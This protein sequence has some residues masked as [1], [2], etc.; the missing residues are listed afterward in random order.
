MPADE[1]SSATNPLDIARD[2][3]EKLRTYEVQDCTGIES[4]ASQNV[5]HLDDE[6]L[7]IEEKL[8]QLNTKRKQWADVERCAVSLRS[9]FRRLPPEVLQDIMLLH[10][11]SY[12]T[13]TTACRST[14][15]V[16][17]VCARWRAVTLTHASLWSTISVKLR[18]K[19][20]TRREVKKIATYLRCSGDK[21]LTI[22]I[23]ATYKAESPF[24][25]AVMEQLMRHTARWKSLHLKDIA[26]M[27]KEGMRWMRALS[28]APLPILEE[29]FLE[30]VDSWDLGRLSCPPNLRTL[31]LSNHFC[32][33][34]PDNFSH[35]QRLCI[36][37]DPSHKDSYLAELVPN[38]AQF[39]LIPE[40]FL[41]GITYDCSVAPDIETEDL[42]EWPVLALTLDFS[43]YRAKSDKERWL[44]PVLWTPCLESLEIVD[45]RDAILVEQ[46]RRF[47]T[48]SH[49]KL[50]TLKI[51]SIGTIKT[52]QLRAVLTLTPNLLNLVLK[53]STEGTLLSANI[54]RDLAIL[55][56]SYNHELIPRLQHLELGLGRRFKHVDALV[57]MV[58]ARCPP[59]IYSKRMISGSLHTVELS[60]CK[61]P[62]RVPRKKLGSV[63][64]SEWD[65][66]SYC[67]SDYDSVYELEPELEDTD[68]SASGHVSSDSVRD[69]V[70][71]LAYERL[72]RLKGRGLAVSFIS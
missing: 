72:L 58:E 65:L 50:T 35:I 53:D 12:T 13:P 63:T 7:R 46:L 44:F 57:Y 28:Q 22:A 52:K 51:F 45:I 19:K 71:Q 14:L 67:E 42:I 36:S 39:T 2:L 40:V 15:R 30:Y 9:A 69:V 6:I 27:L 24:Y 31:N 23:R 20:A 47:L 54:L 60:I 61:P 43:E 66:D 59:Q 49:A 10:F 32:H 18:D 3:R 38:I 33:G 25:D 11:N 56:D 16:A 26:N 41:K 4:I 1:T 21:P 62:K 8:G 34:I 68:L 55:S 37:P 48:Y 5:S 29:M 17:A 64:D 70:G